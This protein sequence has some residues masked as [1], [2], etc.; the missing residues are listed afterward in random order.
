MAI[1][2]GMYLLVKLYL[3]SFLYFHSQTIFNPFF[4]MEI[5]MVGFQRATGMV[6]DIIRKL[7]LKY[8]DDIN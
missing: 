1:T 3:H 8:L 5:A 4:A 6:S 7:V 2:C